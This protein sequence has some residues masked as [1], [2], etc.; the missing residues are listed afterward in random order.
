MHLEKINNAI[1]II[2][3][4]SPNDKFLLL[5]NEVA[6]KRL[7]DKV[8]VTPTLIPNEA[9]TIQA[10]YYH[11]GLNIFRQFNAYVC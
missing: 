1:T 8:L 2:R 11:R 6:V 9:I 10:C 3:Q 5:L 4:P 7:G